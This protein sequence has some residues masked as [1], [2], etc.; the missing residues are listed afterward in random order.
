[1]EE[2]QV[3]LDDDLV[4]HNTRRPHQGG[5]MNGRTPLQAFTQGLPNAQEKWSVLRR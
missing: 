5:G 3:V 2:M 4:G 1:M